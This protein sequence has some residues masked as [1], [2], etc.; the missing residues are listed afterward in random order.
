MHQQPSAL[1]GTRH[2]KLLL[3]YVL[4]FPRLFS[5]GKKGFADT[6]K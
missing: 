1:Q 6:I 3:F 2:E 4:V 5:C